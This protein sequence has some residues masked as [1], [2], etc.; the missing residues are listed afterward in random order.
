MKDACGNEVC[1]GDTVMLAHTAKSAGIR[2]S[3][4]KV[5][6]LT[7]KSFWSWK[8]TTWTPVPDIYESGPYPLRNCIV[9]EKEA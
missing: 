5:S 1:L 8:P 9:V 6:R 3:Q 4:L 2:W 7:E